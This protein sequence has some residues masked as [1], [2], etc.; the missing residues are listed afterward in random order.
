MNSSPPAARVPE[1]V[2]KKSFWLATF[3][4]RP[5]RILGA[6]S[7]LS[8]KSAKQSEKERQA[9]EAHRG[10]IFRDDRG[11]PRP[12]CSSGRPTA[13]PRRRREGREA[14]RADRLPSAAERV[15]PRGDPREGDLDHPA[16]RF[17]LVAKNLLKNASCIGSAILA[18]R[19][20]QH[21]SADR[22]DDL[23]DC[24]PQSYSALIVPGFSRAF[25]HPDPDVDEHGPDVHD[26]GEG[27]PRHRDAAHLD[28]RARSPL[29]QAR[30]AAGR[31]ASAPDDGADPRRRRGV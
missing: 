25:L 14:R 16:Q 2:T 8:A 15:V 9:S 19:R 13:T 20:V 11:L 28:P 3:P 6:I 23:H 26:R 29:Q 21:G 12:A 22:H 17:E 5:D 24:Q 30:P 4:P 7:A 27:E 18:D 31:H 1:L 10:P